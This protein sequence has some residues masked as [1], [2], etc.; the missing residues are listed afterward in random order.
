MAGR[1]WS[2]RIAYDTPK[3]LPPDLDLAK[4]L[5]VH[6]GMREFLTLATSDGD[7]HRGSAMV[8]PKRWPKIRETG[9]SGMIASAK[10]QF[11]RRRRDLQK[12]KRAA[13]SSDG[14]WHS[15]KLYRELEDTEARFVKTVCQQLAG[16]TVRREIRDRQRV[17][18]HRARR[19]ERQTGRVGGRSLSGLAYLAMMIRR[20]PFALQ[21]D[22]I[23]S[24]AEKAGI[25]VE[26]V[27]AAYESQTCPL[28][29][30]VDAKSD[31]G[32][33]TFL[34]TGCELRYNVDAIAAWNALAALGA[35]AHS[36]PRTRNNGEHQGNEDPKT[37]KKGEHT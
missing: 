2:V 5:L 37:R 7:V 17:R 1:N 4:V 21:R 3:P 32:T 6:R 15:T 34:C 23:I 36:W 12:K 14:G 29:K 31:R 19:L 24:A 33:G 22:A 11:H 9:L 16:S 18:S 20:W 8:D 28:C 13:Q 26:T 30:H 25:R 10:K 35:P 27:A